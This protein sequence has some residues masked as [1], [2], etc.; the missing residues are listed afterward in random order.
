VE[1][2]RSFCTKIWNA[3]RFCEMNGI[4]PD[5]AFD[6]GQVR[7]PLA[8]WV[9]DAANRAVAE[10]DSAL[11]AFRFDEYAAASY[12]FAWGTFCDWFLEFAKPVLNNAESPEAAETRRTAA[13]VFGQILRL[14]HPAMPYVTEELWDRFGYGPA[15]SL[16]STAWP[17]AFAVPGAAEARAELDWVVKLIS[18]VRTVR[19]EMNVPPSRLA[20]LLLKDAA[21]ESLARGGRWMEAI[22]RMARASAFEALAGEVPAGS[23]QAVVGEATVVIPLEGV[24]DIAAERA[25]LAKERA[26]VADEAQKIAKKLGNADFVARAKEEVVEENR[27]RLAA[28]E[29]EIERLDSALRR[30]A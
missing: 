29:A 6:T 28:A 8:R 17:E 26:K 3:A 24:I 16:I 11:E 19:A 18:E 14:L 30:I 7:T 2:Y 9:L 12:R 13:H 22:G 21:P 4:S 20:P 27:E 10:A 15:N 23:A 5:R 25:R 1:G